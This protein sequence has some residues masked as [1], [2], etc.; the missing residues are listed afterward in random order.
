MP[1]LRV[2][3]GVRVGE[4]TVSARRLR[5]LSPSC[6]I[7]NGVGEPTSRKDIDI[8]YV[9]GSAYKLKKMIERIG[10]A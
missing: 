5:S 10:H 1:R 3:T 6:R 2:T 7:L 8:E 9:Q 4:A